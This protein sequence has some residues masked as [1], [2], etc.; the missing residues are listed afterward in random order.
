MKNNQYE[1]DKCFRVSTLEQLK[2]GKNVD[3]FK[4]G[5]KYVDEIKLECPKC[6]YNFLE[7]RIVK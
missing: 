2:A 4:C 6:K 3:C 5:Y 1:I 7:G